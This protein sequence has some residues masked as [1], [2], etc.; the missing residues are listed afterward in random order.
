MAEV[1]YMVRH[2]APPV[3][4]RG[5]YWGRGD[6]GVDAE[7][8][9]AVAGLAALP[10]IRPSRLFVSP[11]RRALLTAGELACPLG[12]ECEVLPELAETDFGDF[13]GLT[14]DEIAGRYPDQAAGWAERGDE[15][16]FPGGESISG[17]FERAGRVWRQ[18]ADSPD[19]AVLAV[20]HGG[21]ISAWICLF[22]RLPWAARFTFSIQYSALTAFTRKRDG[23]GWEMTF[24]N[25]VP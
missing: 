25:N 23:S 18:C 11:L 3:E 4:K 15:F 8:L 7:N 1:V 12:L 9:R 20:S 22:L 5:R 16:S 14:F 19:R 24:L 10:Q 17:F 6:P 13:D 21:V 2:A